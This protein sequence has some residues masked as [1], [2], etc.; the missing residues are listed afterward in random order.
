MLGGILIAVLS[1]PMFLAAIFF[2]EVLAG[3]Y[4]LRRGRFAVPEKIP[5]HRIAV[6]IPAHNEGRNILPTLGDAQ[7][8]LEP[9][10]RLLVVADNCSDETAE[11]ARAAGAEV[12]VRND[13]ARR[14]K[15]YALEFGVKYLAIDPPDVVIVMDADCRIERGS[16]RKLSE[17]VMASGRPAQALYLMLCPE[18]APNPVS[19]SEFAWRIKNWLRPIGLRLVGLPSQLFGTGMA[20]PFAALSASNL[21]NSRLAEDTV[22]G[23]E[24]AAAGKPARLVS[25]AKVISYFPVS[26]VGMKTQRE[27]WEKGHLENIFGLAPGFFLMALRDRNLDLAVLAL[28]LA[29]P[30][31][32]LL[33]MLLLACLPLAGI[34]LLLG[35]G[36]A[37]FAVPACGLLLMIA[38]T[39]M[40]WQAVGRDILPAKC[41]FS[42]PL[43]ALQKLGLYRNV[44]SGKAS[45]AWVRTDR[46]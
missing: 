20:F 37:A 26:S 19:A 32:S 12:V 38:A 18:N 15:G 43:L 14:G 42:L 27:R 33:F 17:S 25:E 23:L 11:V 46:Q 13:L 30:P 21:G 22:L 34:A 45:S 35:A 44:A 1:V 9:H 4:A 24:L 10:D 8:E 28:D 39:V 29:V 2:A 5:P 41:L 40:A 16:V 3:S 6:L 36:A 7:A 31:L